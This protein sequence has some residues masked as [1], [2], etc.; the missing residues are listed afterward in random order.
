[1]YQ[2][3]AASNPYTP[4]YTGH[5]PNQYPSANAAVPSAIPYYPLYQG[6]QATKPASSEMQRPDPSEPSVTPQV[7]ARAMQRLVSVELQNAGFER[8]VQPAAQRLEQEVT[9]CKLPNSIDGGSH[10]LMRVQLSSSFSKEHMSTRI[11][12][13][14]PAPLLQMCCLP[15]KS[16]TC[17]L[18]SYIK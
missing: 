6:Q 1:M 4:L 3:E 5:Y 13:I 16:S 9:T 18:K 8:A 15:V 14:A 17:S 11:L 7:A 10:R 2:P 12:L